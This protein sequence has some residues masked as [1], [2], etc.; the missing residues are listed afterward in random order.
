LRCDLRQL[1]DLGGFLPA[2]QTSVFQLPFGREEL[3]RWIQPVV[4]G[5]VNPRAFLSV[6]T[7]SGAKH[8]T[9]LLALATIV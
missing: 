2:D 1:D 9:P 4:R 8:G 3:V 7:A 5:W 6:R